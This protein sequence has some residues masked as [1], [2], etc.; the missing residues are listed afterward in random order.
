M[1]LYADYQKEVYGVGTLETDKGFVTYRIYGPECMIE[2]MYVKPECRKQGYASF[3]ANEVSEIAKREGC[4]ALSCS[5]DPCV[6]GWQYRV[7]A[8]TAYGFKLF[9]MQEDKVIFFKEL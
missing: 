4:I 6:E 3:L 1:S 8:F 2:E 9:D 5:T 7:A